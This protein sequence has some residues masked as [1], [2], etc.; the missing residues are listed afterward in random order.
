MRKTARF[1]IKAEKLAHLINN[2]LRQYEACRGH[3]LLTV[4]RSTA[5]GTDGCNWMPGPL[6]GV[7]N[8]SPYGL[9]VFARIIRDFRLRYNVA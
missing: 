2:E 5:P 1:P 7:S 9:F 8:E 4:E 6:S 3:E